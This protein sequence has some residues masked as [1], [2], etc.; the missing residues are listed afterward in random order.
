MWRNAIHVFGTRV[1][2]RCGVNTIHVCGTGVHE[3]VWCEYHNMRYRCT[4]VCGTG[5]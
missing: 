2:E 4:Q 1:L 3:Q 5:V